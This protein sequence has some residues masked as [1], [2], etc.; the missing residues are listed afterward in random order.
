MEKC[1]KGKTPV[2]VNRQINIAPIIKGDS[3]LTEGVFWKDIKGDQ[4]VV[5]LE[6]FSNS[7]FIESAVPIFEN[8]ID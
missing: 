6:G 2:Y 8:L 5:K 1:S 4:T 3:D 7:T